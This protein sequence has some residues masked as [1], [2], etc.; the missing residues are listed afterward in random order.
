MSLVQVV[1]GYPRNPGL[2]ACALQ[3]I[4]GTIEIVWVGTGMKIASNGYR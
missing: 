1:R 4:L 3:Y 2:P